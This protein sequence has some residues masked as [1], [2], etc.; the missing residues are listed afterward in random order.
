MPVTEMAEVGH[1]GGDGPSRLG[2]QRVDPFP[3]LSGRAFTLV[4]VVLGADG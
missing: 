2:S 1:E 4:T 3:A